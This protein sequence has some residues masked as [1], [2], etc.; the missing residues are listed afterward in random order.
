MTTPLEWVLMA[1]D[2]ASPAFEKLSKTVSRTQSK[3]QGLKAGAG[4][5]AGVALSGVV[6][7]AKGSA[8]A[9]TEAEVKQTALS[10][11]YKKFPA[12]ADVQIGKLRELNEAIERKTGYDHAD[13]D[14]AQSKL[15]MYGLTGKQIEKLTPLIV[16]YAAKTGTGVSES[17]VTIGKAL[18]G[19]GR[20]LKGVGVAFKD[21]KSLAGNYSEVIGGLTAKVGGYANTVG[22]T[23]AGKSKIL[24]AEFQNLQQKA[25]ALL[26]PALSKLVDIGVKVTTWLNK[27][28]AAFQAIAAVV[29]LL[30]AG[31]VGLN[32][33]LWATAAA[34][35]GV[36]WPVM[37]VI[38]AIA[39]LI[40]IIVFLATHWK[41]IW[42]GIQRIT[43]AVVNW[44][45]ARGE[46]FAH[47]WTAMWGQV[48]NFIKTVWTGFTSWVS[49]TWNNFLNGIRFGL[50]VL[51]AA[52]NIA[53]ARIGTF[54]SDIW[55]NHIVAPIRNAW[56]WIVNA[57]HAGL[58]LISS[59]WNGTWQAIGN[60]V[61]NI[62][63]GIVG[64]VEGGVNRVIGVING[65]IG[66][67]SSVT[68]V[69]GV[70]L[71]KL[72]NLPAHATGTAY[73][74]GGLALV[75]ERGP[76]VVN[77]PVGSKVN[78]SGVRPG[79]SQTDLSERSLQR[80]ARMLAAEIQ[81]GAEHTVLASFE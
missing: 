25:G 37:L 67:V 80:L 64:F 26:V 27:N 19:Q 16:D 49:S 40:A 62:W 81:R 73:S 74:Q 18:L 38:A 59:A 31:L 8:D 11:A 51:G 21:T 28:P 5:L 79:G 50:A 75:G 24:G 20:A 35:T 55:N 60:I 43:A 52:W 53:W 7:F 12:L 65:I 23:A 15:A 6:A 3:L 71:G 69:V 54:L 33:A 44:I 36:L 68:S 76:E 39:A 56:N 4:I 29:V 42:A 13:L 48:G 41:E 17:A 34:E 58:S 10:A 61:K 46:A 45:T 22:E 57:V 32:I 1:R 78:P 66:A 30:V 9:F 77:L 70:K 2:E 72:P 14:L 63:N 47:S